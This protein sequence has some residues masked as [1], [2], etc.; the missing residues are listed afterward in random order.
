MFSVLSFFA[1]RVVTQAEQRSLNTRAQSQL[2]G[3]LFTSLGL[4]DGRRSL[5][6]N[7]SITTGETGRDA[8]PCAAVQ[9]ST[10]RQ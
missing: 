10:S 1:V 8:R 6:P 7:P 3:L 9:S 5:R 4:I 2:M